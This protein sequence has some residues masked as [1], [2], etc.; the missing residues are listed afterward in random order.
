MSTPAPTVSF[1][2]V[3]DWEHHPICECWHG[4][5]HCGQPAQRMVVEHAPCKRLFYVCVPCLEDMRAEFAQGDRCDKCGIVFH[6][7]TVCFPR[8]VSI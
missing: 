8:V 5:G 4:T 1:L 3:A 2:D 7:F 6:E